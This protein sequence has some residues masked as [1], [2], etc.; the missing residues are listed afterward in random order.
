MRIFR[1]AVMS[2][3]D[4]A[5]RFSESYPAVPGSV[6]LAREATAA[7]AAHAGA[8]VRAIDAVRLA[9]SEAVTNA[10]VHAYDDDSG[11]INVAAWLVA[12]ELW[13]LVADHGHGLRPHCDRLGLG[14]GLG[15]MAQ[16]SDGFAVANRPG[17]GTELRM[18]FALNPAED[19][20][21]VTSATF[22]AS[23]PFSTIGRGPA[24]AFL[25]TTS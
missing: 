16:L 5:A 22:P 1:K 17:G 6:R 10:V 3:F 2:E 24:H 23:R 7:F 21:Q 4:P 20:D 8:S 12:G 11:R 13:L 9:A 14:L 19:S 25:S 18:R 15:L